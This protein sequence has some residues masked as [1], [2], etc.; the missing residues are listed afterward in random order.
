MGTIGTKNSLS[1]WQLLRLVI[2]EDFVFL[3]LGIFNHDFLLFGQWIKVTA[4]LAD[5]P[6]AG[7]RT[8]DEKQLKTKRTKLH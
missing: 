8:L 4:Y 7:C 5:Q 6:I 2:L 3:F 1:D